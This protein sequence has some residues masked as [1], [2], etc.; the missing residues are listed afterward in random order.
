MDHSTPISKLPLDGIEHAEQ[1]WLQNYLTQRSQI[2]FFEG[3]PQEEDITYG[4]PQGSILGPLLFLIHIN[5]VHLHVEN[6]K[7]IMYADDTVLLFSDK[8]EDEI[9]KAINHDAN[10]LH[11]WLCNNGL[12]LNSNKGKTEFMMFG[13]AT[14]RKR[15]ENEMTIEISS[16]P[17]SNTDSY[18]YLGIHL[19]PSLSLTDHVHKVYKKASRRLGLLRRI[20]PILTILTIHAALDLYKA[21]V[22]PVMTYCSTTFLSVSETNGKKFE[23]LEKRAAK[24]ILGARY[25]Q[26]D[27]VF[28]SFANM[29]NIQ[30]ADFVFRC[31]NK[32]APDVFHDHFEKIDHQKATSANG[33]NLKIPKVKTESAK[34][35]FYFSGVKIYNALPS[36]LKTERFYPPFKQK[37]KEHFTD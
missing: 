31:L 18:K 8:T 37:L 11:T 34:R 16:K 23:R 30:C 33:L 29:Q 13:T 3:E 17:I 12:I 4:V 28:R 10:L 14:R 26:Q 25:Q 36:H 24:I 6:C 5:D 7:T 21:M 1:R 20:R 32:T 19:D 35:G 27:R 9:N 2:T 22:Q 15:I